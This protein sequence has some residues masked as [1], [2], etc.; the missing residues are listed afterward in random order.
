MESREAI[1]A[2]V[3]AEYDQRLAETLAS[4]TPDQLALRAANA[5]T[6]YRGRRRNTIERE[7]GRVVYRSIHPYVG[8]RPLQRKR[9]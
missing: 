8:I 7:P 6:P 5:A 1:I 9:V 2:R 4:M 3:M